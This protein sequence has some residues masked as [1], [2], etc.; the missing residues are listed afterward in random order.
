MTENVGIYNIAQFV[1]NHLCSHYL[2]N[3]I[4]EEIKLFSHNME[5]RSPSE[6]N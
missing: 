2:Y 4:N 5:Q 6:T 1:Q 3:D